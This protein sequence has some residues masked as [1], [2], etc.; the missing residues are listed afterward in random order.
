[1]KKSLLLAS[2]LCLSI[3]L[4][5]QG[6]RILAPNYAGTASIGVPGPAND[7]LAWLEHDGFGGATDKPLIQPPF[8]F[9]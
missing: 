5:G 8:I 2:L 4:L 7:D 6:S 9:T 1:M 3:S